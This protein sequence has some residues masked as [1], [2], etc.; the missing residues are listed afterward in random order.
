[1]KNYKKSLQEIRT[2][3]QGINFYFGNSYFCAKCIWSKSYPLWLWV[4]FEIQSKFTYTIL[5]VVVAH[6]VLLF[7][8][9]AAAVLLF[10]LLLAVIATAI[11]PPFCLQCQLQPYP[12]EFNWFS[13]I[14]SAPRYIDKAFACNTRRSQIHWDT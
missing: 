5:V 1:M 8:V 9:G 6:L 14:N 7:V 11:R 2:N 10:R 4:K 13:L 3:L 12:R